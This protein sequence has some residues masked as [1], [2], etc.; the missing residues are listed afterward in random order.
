MEH[1]EALTPDKASEDSLRTTPTPATTFGPGARVSLHAIRDPSSRFGAVAAPHRDHPGETSV[2]PFT[3]RL[4]TG[5]LMAF[6]L[7]AIA[8]SPSQ[9]GV[10]VTGQ[11]TAVAPP[12]S[13]QKGADQ[14]STT[15]I[16]FEERSSFALPS[17]IAVNVTAPGTSNTGNSY[18]PSPGTVAAGTLTDIWFFHSDP[19]GSVPTN[20][21]GTATFDSPILGIL[22][23]L[24]TL[25]ATD[26]TLGHPGTAY[27]TGLPNRA[28]EAPDTFTLSADDRTI[29]FSFHTSG[30]VDEI[31]VL[32]AAVPEPSTMLTSAACAGGLIAFG[33]FRR[34]RRG[35]RAQVG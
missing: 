26:A 3:R 24:S 21:V 32:V 7:G 11:L 6:V 2:I 19:P 13:V 10:V 22:D 14:S 20:Y 16:I 1:P 27:P 23:T 34:L 9:A 30:A 17:N 12:P 35:S 25:N 8:A 31:R 18:N 28:L 15:A 33:A 29:S 4:P 5:L